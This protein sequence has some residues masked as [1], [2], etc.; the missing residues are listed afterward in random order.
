MTKKKALGIITA[1]GGSK[2]LPGKNI[3][4]LNGKP[5]IVWTIE[6]ALSSKNL[7][8]VMVST[9]CPKIAAIS[10][11]AG[12]EIPFF[13]PAKFA[14]DTASSVSVVN[15]VLEH[16]DNRGEFF[17]YIVLLEPTSPLREADDIDNMLK[18]VFAKESEGYNGILAI[19]EAAH[20]SILRVKIG[21][22][23]LPYDSSLQVYSHRQDAQKVYFPFGV[24]YIVKTDVFR[25]N[26]SFY[27]DNMLFY[28]LKKYQWYEI[29]DIYDFLAVENI[30]KYQWFPSN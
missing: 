5:L 22:H 13:R 17:D 24:A 23:L 4:R 14:N 8:K 15:H 29:D 21:D 18:K 3:K 11:K 12:A 2:G 7:T 26:Q 30:M 16:Y 19:G 27:P 1:R 6:R 25:K 10:E 28:E 9:D 20:P